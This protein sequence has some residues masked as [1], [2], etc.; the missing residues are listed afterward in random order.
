MG[1]VIGDRRRGDA[2]CLEHS[3]DL[4]RGGLFLS[5]LARDGHEFGQQLDRLGIVDQGQN[6]VGSVAHHRVQSA[7][8]FGGE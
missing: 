2:R 1:I 5:A 4:R 7:G 8:V 6:V 3:L